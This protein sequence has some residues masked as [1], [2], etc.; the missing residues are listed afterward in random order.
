MIKIIVLIFQIALLKKIIYSIIV[1]IK[2][3]NFED[4]FEQKDRNEI[5]DHIKIDSNLT[6]N[7]VKNEAN[8]WYMY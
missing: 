7:I 1:S 6:K 4:R 2:N 3:H 8:E 5:L